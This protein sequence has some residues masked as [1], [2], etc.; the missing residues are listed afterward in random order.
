[1]P[2]VR[3]KIPGVG[4]VNK[5][6][7]LRI[8]NRKSSQGAHHMSTEDLIKAYVHDTN[9][10]HKNKINTVLRLRG[11]DINAVLEE[12]TAPETAE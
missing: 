7:K 2:K 4:T 1:M 9:T 5:T 12:R 11:V 8:G 6:T 3:R 10:R